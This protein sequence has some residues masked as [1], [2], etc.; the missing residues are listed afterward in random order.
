MNDQRAGSLVVLP[1]KGLD[2]KTKEVIP[3]GEV[4]VYSMKTVDEKMFGGISKRI[5]FETVIDTLIRRCSNIPES[6]RPE[7]L[8]TGDRVFLML[9]IRAASYGAQYSF[10]VQCP[11]C[12]AR[13]SHTMDLTK[14]L[15][16]LEAQNSHQDP[17]EVEMSN[18]E[19]VTLRLFRGSDEKAIIKY[20]DRQNKKVDIRT[21]GDP[22]YIYRLALH[23]VGVKSDDNP[24]HNFD[25]DICVQ[26]GSLFA[27]AQTYIEKLDARDSSVVREEID[28]RTPGVKLL[29]DVECPKCRHEFDLALPMS[30]DFFRASGTTSGLHSKSGVV[31]RST[32]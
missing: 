21:V 14:D 12:R 22:G 8:Y 24:D 27:N 28:N 19:R 10:E 4:T 6:V 17:F 13:W 9:N 5:D 31:P 2:P 1:S 18:G 23:V 15:E 3:R 32:R 26:P 11:E 29:M 7:D 16:I 20:V 30:A 25:E